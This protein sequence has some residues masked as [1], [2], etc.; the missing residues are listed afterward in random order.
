[1][2]SE[3]L[4]PRPSSFRPFLS[5]PILDQL[6]VF[7]HF[8]SKSAEKRPVLYSYGLAALVIG[9]SNPP[10]SPWLP[11]G[12][13]P[14]SRPSG[15]L[16]LGELVQVGSVVLSEHAGHRELTTTTSQVVTITTLKEAIGKANP[17]QQ[18]PKD[19]IPIPNP[20]ERK[21]NT[22][23]QAHRLAHLHARLTMGA[24]PQIPYQLGHQCPRFLPRRD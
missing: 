8:L 14:P 15:R 22:T 6:D 19:P 13:F 9:I 10:P 7:S 18:A 17:R 16:L 3:R 4:N 23:T 21:S 11:S 5:R 12:S 20:A 2:R 24:I 1:M